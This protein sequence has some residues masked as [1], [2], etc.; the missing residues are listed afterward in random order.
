[1]L[2][3]KGKRRKKLKGHNRKTDKITA[4]NFWIILLI[5]ILNVADGLLTF[6][7]FSF[8]TGTEERNPLLAKDNL[9]IGIERVIGSTIFSLL[10]ILFILFLGLW[11][12][13]IVKIFLYIWLIS[14][15]AI[16]GLGIYSAVIIFTPFPY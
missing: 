12:Y 16:A 15:I 5:I 2:Y 6:Y 13:K 7:C 9:T 4:V 10:V 8:G 14:E 1:M 11:R 3:L